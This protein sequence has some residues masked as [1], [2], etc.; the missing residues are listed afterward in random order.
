M[1]AERFVASTRDGDVQQAPDAV[2][3]IDA[4]LTWTNSGESAQLV[5]L[6]TQR[7]PRA[8]T[9]S[10]PNTYVLDDGLSWDIA[11]SPNAPTPYGVQNGVGA[12]LQTTPV[13]VNQ[14]GYGRIFRGWDDSIRYDT[15]GTV[16]PGETVHVRYQALY[17]SPGQW[18][19][20]A[21]VLQV[22]RAYWVRMRLWAGP[23]DTP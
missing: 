16:E 9:A 17:T 1:V 19:A 8:I 4:E 10:N 14:V 5:R 20:P 6:G 11:V 22:V 3:F 18:R 13:A 2:P 12:R 21:Q 15:L 7:A 23:E